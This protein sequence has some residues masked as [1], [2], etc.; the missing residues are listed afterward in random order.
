MLAPNV[1][2]VADTDRT[3]Q[4]VGV[5]PCARIPI[6]SIELEML[7][8]NFAEE[9]QCR[10]RG[11]ERHREQRAVLTHDYPERQPDYG[12]RDGAAKST[13]HRSC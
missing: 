2:A 3:Q 13:E 8:V 1:H 9:Q 5:Q 12:C 10:K 7:R 11:G 6:V 4:D